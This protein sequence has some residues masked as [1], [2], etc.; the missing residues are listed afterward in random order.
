MLSFRELLKEEQKKEKKA[1]LA[2]GRYN[3]PTTGH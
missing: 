2:F 3:P 1:V